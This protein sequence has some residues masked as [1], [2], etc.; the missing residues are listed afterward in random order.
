MSDDGSGGM[1]ITL[2]FGTPT[3][4]PPTT[5]SGA[6]KNTTEIKQTIA[7]AKQLDKTKVQLVKQKEIKHLKDVPRINL[8]SNNVKQLE[9]SKFGIKA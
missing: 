4:P 7:G 9:N 5:Q 8:S 1:V 6:K 2:K 3:P